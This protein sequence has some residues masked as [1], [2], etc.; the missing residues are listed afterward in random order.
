MRHL[1]PLAAVRVFEAAARHQNFTTAATELGMTQ[2]AV[3]HQI[4]ILEERLGT[5][6]FRRERRRVVLTEPGRRA[7]AELTRAFDMI[8]AAFGAVRTEDETLL[9]VSTSNIFASTWFAWRLGGFHMAHPGLAVRLHTSDALVDFAASAVDCAVRSGPGGW[10][11][12][13]ENL[14]TRVDFTPMCSPDFLARHGGSIAPADLLGLPLI[15]RQDPWWTHWLEEAG[16]MIGAGALRPGVRLDSQAHEGNAAIA[17]QGMAMLTPFF[18]RSE[19]AQGRLVAPFPQISTQGHGHW[20]VCPE[21]RR[22]VPKIK[23]FREWL[24]AE[25]ARD[26]AG[27]APS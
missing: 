22:G 9:T 19:L 20:L 17:G 15:S 5:S 16:V 10:S 25:V 23:R 2:A 18:W 21:H 1:P 26:Q 6:L 8:D 24:L 14:L 3:S 13:S 27:T 12:L 7:A 4:R 11:G